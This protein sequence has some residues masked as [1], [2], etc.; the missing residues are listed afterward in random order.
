M[1]PIG[2][3]RA[4]AVADLVTSILAIELMASA[5]AI[6][7]RKRKPSRRSAAVVQAVRT[8]VPFREVDS[9]WHDALERVRDIV[10]DGTIA[11]AAGLLPARRR[12]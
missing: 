11:R 7:L 5:Q 1:A 8:A 4:L 10:R 3:R 12:R 9:P 6:D 2:A